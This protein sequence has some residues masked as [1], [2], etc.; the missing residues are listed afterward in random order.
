MQPDPVNV[1]IGIVVRDGHILICQ[2]RNKG[3]LGGLWEFPGGKKEPGE[4]PDSCLF[5]E[6][7]EELGIV[8][9]VIEPFAPIDW[10]YPS[11]HVRLLPYLCD[12]VSGEPAPL[13]CQQLA[14]VEPKA[15]P[16]YR[17]PPANDDL[18]A[19]LVGRFKP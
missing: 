5:R 3:H 17:F 9:R 13:A 6:L 8:V 4:T 18:I 16:E 11:V 19:K 10:Q 2:R 7:R 1:A 14:W 12:L 15:L